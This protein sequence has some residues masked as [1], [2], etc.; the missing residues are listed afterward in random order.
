[1]LAYPTPTFDAKTIRQA[2]GF[3]PLGKSGQTIP[4]DEPVAVTPEN[5]VNRHTTNGGYVGSRARNFI[6]NNQFLNSKYDPEK[7]TPLSKVGSVGNVGDQFISA[8]R[9]FMAEPKNEELRLIMNILDGKPLADEQKGRLTAGQ[10][11][12]LGE[13]SQKLAQ[14][15]KGEM[16]IIDDLRDSQDALSKANRIRN[17]MAQGFTFEEASKA[18]EKLREREAEKALFQQQDTSV[19]LYDLIDSKVGGTQNPLTPGNDESALAL[20]VG[21]NKRLAERAIKVNEGMD[22]KTQA[23]TGE[24]A[25][26]TTRLTAPQ[27]TFF[28]T[29]TVPRVPAFVRTLLES[30][31]RGARIGETLTLE[32]TPQR[33]TV[34]PLGE[35][36]MEAIRRKGGRPRDL[37]LALKTNVPVEAIR[38]ERKARKEETQV[39]RNR[40]EIEEAIARMERAQAEV[41]KKKIKIR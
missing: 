38:A 32:E 22:R 28:Q 18:Y 12:A 14:R 29:G 37:A 27:V 16:G 9:P 40:R 25:G 6:Q 30:A 24:L 15:P 2:P 20:A 8:G 19:R 26:L 35:A 21:R 10:V 11:R 41:D 1:M 4:C 5:K 17:A 34:T 33:L 13:K 39:E 23:T 3:K 31:G 36:V 7:G